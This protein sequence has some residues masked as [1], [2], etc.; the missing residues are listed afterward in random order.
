MKKITLIVTCS[1]ILLAGLITGCSRSGKEKNK[2]VRYDGPEELARM[3]W[4]R[5][6]DPAT[7]KVPR[8]RLVPALN[9][10][11]YLRSIFITIN[12]AGVWTERGPDKDTVGVSN[13]NTRANSGVASGRVRAFLVDAA[14]V[15]GNTVW[16]GG[17]NGG[18]WK[19]TNITAAPATWVP[20]NDFF[21]NMAVTSMCQDP[22]NASIMYFGTGE[23]FF[24]LDAVGGDGIWKTTNGGTTWT[25]LAF[26]TSASF[27]YCTK[28]ECD[29]A[30]NVYAATRSGLFRTTDGGTNWT[31]ITPTGLS[32]RIS[33][34]EISS[35]GRLHVS[36]GIFSTCA[37]RFTDAPATVAAAT[38][39]TPTAGYPASNIRIEL[40]CSGNVLYALPS[41]ANRQVPTIYKSTDGGANWAVTGGQPTAGW[42]GGQA[43][44][45]LAGDIDPANSNNVVV[46]GLEPY[47]STDGGNSW[48]RIGRWVGTTGQYVHADIHKIDW[49]GTNR[50]IFACDGGIHYSDDAGTTIRDRNVGLRIKQFYSCDYHP[51]TADYFLAGAQDNGTHRF[52]TAGLA[53]TTEITGGDGAFVR[54]DQNEP[55]YQYGAYV[56]NAYRRSSNSG[57]N[58]SSIQFYRGSPGTYGVNYD[59]FG[60]FI[61]PFDYDN[62][63]NILYGGA[64]NDEFFR[65]TTPQTT[66]AGTYYSATNFA[67]A[68]AEI[69]P[70]IALGG[71]AVTTVSV[72][73]YTANRVY[74][75]SSNG[76]LVSLDNANTGSAGTDISGASFPVAP[77]TCVN[78]GTTDN[79][80]IVSF[81]NYG[82]SNVWVTTDGGTSWSRI[83]GNLPDMPVRW[84]MFYPGDNTRAIIATEAG[85]WVT[86]LINGLSTSWYVSSTFPLVRTDMIKYR[87]SDGMLV[88]ATHGRGLFTQLATSIFP[89]NE[90]ALSGSFNNDN[91]TTVKWHYEMSSSRTRFEVQA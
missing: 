70:L 8:N 65:W 41:D 17:V 67:T 45:N 10:A 23:G 4:E 69:V 89:L 71:S 30:G 22:T 13:G 77:I 34:I 25:Q 33:D 68:N 1:T 59:D 51:T 56:Y 42:A 75:G 76:T 55:T 83:D 50:M 20:Q 64:D 19:T 24:N 66:A 79:N 80:L 31:N 88:A 36:S 87:P 57:S 85:V 27:D 28:L 84:C 49:Y 38:W 86:E 40:V 2:P 32:T 21:S 29:N 62:T 3:E 52:R 60:S 47:R 39:T 35:T 54:V 7:G 73:P 15:S 18:L 11:E 48:T 26:T 63:A 16:V 61:N 53:G 6:K 78:T 58:W 46:G 37:Y 9:Y 72:S 14:D 43:W 91:T 44:Y 12:A 82:V 81:A 74:F 5:T 90:F